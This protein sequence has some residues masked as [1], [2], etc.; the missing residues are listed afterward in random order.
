M[1]QN[2]VMTYKRG[3]ENYQ[4]LVRVP[5]KP[6]WRELTD[7]VVDEEMNLDLPLD[8]LEIGSD[9]KGYER[10]DPEVLLPVSL[11]EVEAV[12]RMRFDSHM[13]MEAPPQRPVQ[14]HRRQYCNMLGSTA[15]STIILRLRREFQ[16]DREAT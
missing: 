7:T 14:T 6:V 9:E 5:N 13:E 11:A 2:R 10:Y 8:E 15:T 12:K 3:I 1:K 16:L 4:A